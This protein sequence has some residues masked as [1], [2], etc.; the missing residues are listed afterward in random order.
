M[1]SNNKVITILYDLLNLHGVILF[2]LQVAC[3]L[4]STRVYEISNSSVCN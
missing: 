1:G 2:P 4:T 3:V